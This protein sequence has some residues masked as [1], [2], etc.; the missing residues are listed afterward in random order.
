MVR[1]RLLVLARQPGVVN[2]GQG[3]PDYDGSKA[4]R[5]AAAEAMIDP[6]KVK[7]A[8]RSNVKNACCPVL[9][10]MPEP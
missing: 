9:L 6:T 8:G 3:F 4:A 2:L 7:D 5:E 10:G 1:A